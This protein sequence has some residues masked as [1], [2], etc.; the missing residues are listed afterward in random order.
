MK[1]TFL[2]AATLGDDIVEKLNDIFGGF[3]NLAINL[4]VESDKVAET[5]GDSDIVIV[6]KIKLNKL[7]LENAHNLKLICVTATG[8]DNI[9]TEYCKNRGIAV[10][11]VVGYSTQSVAQLTV[12]MALT[13]I[14]KLPQYTDFV[15]SGAYTKSG[16]AN[17][18]TPVYHEISGKVWGIVGLGNIGRSVA[19]VAEALGCE[20]IVNKRTPDRN[21]KC[22][23]IETLC[24]EADIISI[25][26]PLTEDT[27]KLI[28]RDR[29]AMMKKD[30]IVINVARGD[31]VDEEALCDA[32]IDEK[33][34][35]L[36][37][38]VYSAEPLPK[39]HK[40]N[41][42]LDYPNVCF[43]PHSAWG[44]YEARLRC[45]DIIKENI[46]VF[47]KGGEKNRVE[48]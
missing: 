45:M 26:T 25:H 34:G 27:R 46:S 9:D 7:N 30:A 20:I 33:I 17:R 13:L 43:T 36:G 29:I 18:L 2:D 40:Y 24:K 44:A 22:V 10:C 47:L 8:Y 48:K 37:I 12:L 14:N 1:L 23:D 5:I 19:K 4:S 38:D 16:V 35:G 42:I 41:K 31:V 11:N 32:I 28:N 15:K 6:N 39:E 3:G 21:F